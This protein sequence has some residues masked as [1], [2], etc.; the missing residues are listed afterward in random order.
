MATQTEIA[1]TGLKELFDLWDSRAALYREVTGTQTEDEC[2]R[3]A[4]LEVLG[5]MGAVTHPIQGP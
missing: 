3:A 1:K 2:R 4:L 5:K